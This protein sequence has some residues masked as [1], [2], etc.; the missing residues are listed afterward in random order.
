VSGALSGALPGAVSGA[1]SCACG[2]TGVLLRPLAGAPV[3]VSA[4]PHR[5]SIAA[6]Y[7]AVMSGGRPVAP[8]PQR[9]RDSGESWRRSPSWSLD[10]APAQDCLRAA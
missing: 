8:Y 4:T 6:V 5:F 9:R 7:E 2:T 3:G 10:Q 1:V